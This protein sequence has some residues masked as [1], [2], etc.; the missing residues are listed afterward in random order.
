MLVSVVPDGAVLVSE[1]L[2]PGEA[3]RLRLRA[4][5][6]TLETGDEG[7]VVVEPGS[8]VGVPAGLVLAEGI[9]T[10]QVQT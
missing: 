3:T 7:A 4:G 10:N 6:P 5:V 2:L 1:Q 9:L 8:A